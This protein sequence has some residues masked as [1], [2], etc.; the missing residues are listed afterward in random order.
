MDEHLDC[1][2]AVLACLQ[3]EGLKVKL[4]KCG[5]K[6]EVKYPGLCHIISSDGV[7]TDPDKI[8][9]LLLTGLAPPLF[10]SCVPL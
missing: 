8:M 9:M 5:F 1:L 4:E 6:K 3:Q 2:G 7:L 10:L